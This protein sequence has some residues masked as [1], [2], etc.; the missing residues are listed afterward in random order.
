MKCHG[1]GW[2]YLFKVDT[3]AEVTA[4]SEKTYCTFVNA[5]AQLQKSPHTLRDANH[6]PLDVVGESQMTFH[7]NDKCT[8]QRSICS[9]GFTT[10]LI[11][12]TSH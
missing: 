2:W 9:P 4:L 11:R 6:T 7:Y 12:S 3:G 10:Q 5:L 1:V 8:V